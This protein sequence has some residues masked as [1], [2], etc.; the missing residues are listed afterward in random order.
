MLAVVAHYLLTE[1]RPVLLLYITFKAYLQDTILYSVL[2]GFLVWNDGT[3]QRVS[4]N[5]TST[6]DL[7]DYMDCVRDDVT[8]SLFSYTRHLD[9]KCAPIPDSMHIVDLVMNTLAGALCVCFLTILLVQLC[10]SGVRSISEG[11]YIAFT[12]GIRR[13]KTYKVMSGI[14]VIFILYLLG[15]NIATLV[16][17]IRAGNTHKVVEFLETY[18]SEALVL[19]YSAVLLFQ[20]YEPSF[21]FYSE[22]F[23]SL[24]FQRGTSAIFSETNTDFCTALELALYKDSYLASADLKAMLPPDGSTTQH[25]VREACRPIDAKEGT[26]RSRPLTKLSDGDGSSGSDSEAPS[27]TGRGGCC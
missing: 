17:E 20:S 7:G 15:R 25:A 4:G 9:Y 24:D 14:E 27:V 6:E 5:A 12:L 2:H 23:Q 8:G 26:A 16:G 11:R 22:A 21:D 10:A 13:S 19:L 1:F 18:G 3:L